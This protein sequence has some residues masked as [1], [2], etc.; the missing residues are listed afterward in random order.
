MGKEARHTRRDFWVTKLRKFLTDHQY[1]RYAIK[2]YGIVAKRFLNYA[3]SRGISLESFQ[4]DLVESYLRL[5]LNR[6]RHKHR[7]HPHGMSGWRWHFL[8]PIHKLLALAQGAWP[9]P[10]AAEARV[11]WFEGELK[12]AEHS[13]STIRTYVRI[14]RGFLNY[15]HRAGIA[16][17]DVE[18]SHVSSFID[19][20]LGLYRHR[21][22]RMPGQVVNWRCGLSSAIHLLLK[23]A[24]GIWPPRELPDPQIDRLAKQLK[25]EAFAPPTIA[26]HLRRVRHFLRYLEERGISFDQ[27]QL[28]DVRSYRWT[29]L[30]AYR[31]KHGRQPLNQRQWSVGITAPVNRLLRNVCGVWPPGS[32][33]DPKIEEFRQQLLA[34]GF[35]ATVIPSQLSH[36]R[37]FLRYLKEHGKTLASVQT[38]DVS[39]YLRARLAL[40]RQRNGRGP[41]NSTWHYKQT[42]PIHRLLRMVR[43]QWPPAEAAKDKLELWRCKLLSDYATWMVD[44]RGL[45]QP[46]VRKNSHAAGVFLQWLGDAARVDKLQ[47]LTV[48]TI[49]RFLAWR[50]PKLRRATRSGVV[51][52]LR[53]FLRFLHHKH[54]LER[55]FASAVPRVSLYRFEDVPKVFKPDQVK[56]L[57]KHIYEDKSPL[58]LRDYAIV[59]LL[60]RYGL[61]AGEIVR[62]RL[63]HIDWRREEFR[64]VQSKSYLPLR[65]PLST[66]V[67]NA[68]LR[69]LRRGR[70]HSNAREVFLRSRAPQGCFR[71]GSSLYSVIQRRLQQA[72]IH[73]EGRR[74]SHAFRY[75]H[76]GNLLRAQVAFKTIGDLLGHRSPASTGIYLKLATD[77]LRSVALEVPGGTR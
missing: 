1:S 21:H 10:S 69:Y 24:Q 46:T 5:E 7:R 55:D 9:P 76:A 18:P 8:S 64:V 44:L 72:G 58:G 66:E 31:K 77:D 32:E 62:M 42:G 49:D 68:I 75:A 45:S 39:A 73:V 4:P 22:H 30:T 23:K 65:L 56:A 52:C 15:L 57:L 20:E 12:A 48:P 59:L 50:T 38:E 51:H 19:Q 33:A 47:K 35:S 27:V 61:R 14:S 71:C 70:P 37:C 36:V 41:R 40:Y 43:G 26:H 13:Q 3:E 11:Q 74:G 29:Q 25:K 63:E 53:D 2:N 60:A 16:L 54:Y 34:Q 28:T 17:C 67:G 6:Y